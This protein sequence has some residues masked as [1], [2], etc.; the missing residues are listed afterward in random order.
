MDSRVSLFSYCISY[1]F[2]ASFVLLHQRSPHPLMEACKYLRRHPSYPCQCHHLE[3]ELCLMQSF[4]TYTD[5]ALD[6]FES[7]SD[8][9]LFYGVICRK[10]RV[11]SLYSSFYRMLCKGLLLVR[12]GSHIG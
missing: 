8:Q 7:R 1:T 9:V 6:P 10:F 2:P 11:G 12:L 5:N 3:V 4:F